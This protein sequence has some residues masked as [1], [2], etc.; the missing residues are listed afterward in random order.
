[1]RPAPFEGFVT[2]AIHH[3]GYAWR[4]SCATRP[5]VMHSAII[6]LFLSLTDTGIATDT[7]LSEKLSYVSVNVS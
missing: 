4:N 6:W 7:M 3:E 2:A 5:Y 1:M